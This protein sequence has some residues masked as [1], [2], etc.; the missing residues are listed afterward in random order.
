MSEITGDSGA[1]T[2]A[3]W[4]EVA[5]TVASERDRHEQN[6][7]RLLSAAKEWR[8]EANKSPFMSAADR[9]F[10]AVIESLSER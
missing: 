1:F 5:H 9:D 2:V 7:D 4:E 10:I 3:E 6:F 8:D